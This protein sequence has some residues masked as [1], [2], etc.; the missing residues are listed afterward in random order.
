M[1]PSADEDLLAWAREVRG[2]EQLQA[3][4]AVL[5]Q[6]RAFLWAKQAESVRTATHVV[7]EGYPDWWARGRRAPPGLEIE[8]QEDL[9]ELYRHAGALFSL[10]IPLTLAERRTSA[11]RFFQDV[12]AWGTRET[13][14]TVEELVGPDEPLTR[15]VG[16][17]MAEVFPQ[18]A[19]PG[20]FLDAAVYDATGLSQTKGV[21]KTSLRLVWPRIV[22]DSDRASRVR[23]LL[24]KRV[25]AAAAEEP[26]AALQGRLRELCAGNAWHSVF[27]DAAYAVRSSVRMPLCD[28]VSPLPLRAAERRPLAPVGV[29]RFDFA[30]GKMKVEW[31]CRQAELEGAEWI[32]IGC[33]RQP[34]DA[35]LT[36]WTAPAWPANQPIPTSSTRTGR[37]KVRTTGGSDGS[38]ARLR[39]VKAAPAPERAGQLLTVERR[40]SL[41]PEQLCERMEQHLG[42]AFV[43]PDGAF[44]WKQPGGDARIVMYADDKRLK[45]VGRP[46][47]VRSLVVIVAPFTEAQ[48]APGQQGWAQAAGPQMPD[49]RNPSEAY[50]PLA[51]EGGGQDAGSKAQEAAASPSTEG[52]RPLTGQLRIARQGF[53]PQGQGEL[54]LTEGMLV[55]IT[56]DP[57][58]EHGSCEDR[59]VYGC[60][61]AN[62]QLGWFPLS[63][64]ALSEESCNGG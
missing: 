29:L 21:R 13:A 39:A 53:E 57:E 5:E 49:G 60:S 58:G 3:D 35:Q 15:L 44:V 56:H 4:P 31:L 34:P 8:R 10:G 14:M 9:E 28:R 55:R 20:G 47:Q 64:T 40:F 24:V 48:P 62:G 59:W 51:G 43:E 54:E 19:Q 42:K 27:G 36:E 7:L 32:K 50:A 22:V 41:A 1:A 16:T 61:E 25:A 26:L 2:D 30:E 23:D 46:N 33:V 18:H 11:F 17:V 38:G 45:V 6:V 12:E 52:A 37:V 63:H